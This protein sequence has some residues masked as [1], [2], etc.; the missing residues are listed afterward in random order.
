MLSFLEFYETLLSFVLYKL[1]HNIGLYYPPQ[2]DQEKDANGE[3]IDALILKPS[4]SAIIE[5]KVAD[6]IANEEEMKKT[7]VSNEDSEQSK[8]EKDE[9][10][11]KNLFSKCYFFLARE[12][13]RAKSIFF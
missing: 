2:F 1:Y 8:M 5:S 11:F 13:S 4:E 6:D 7:F 10:D 12:V 3:V 9:E